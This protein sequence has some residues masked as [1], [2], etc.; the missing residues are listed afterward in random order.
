VD[1]RVALLTVPSLAILG[2]LVTH[3]FVT[4][5]RSRAVAFWSSVVGYGILRGLALRWVIDHGLGASFPY[6]IRNPLF[7]VFGVPAQEIMGWAIVT[8]IGWWL[9]ARFSRYLFAQIAWACLFLGTISWAVESAAVAI[10][11]WRW[12]VP[13]TQSVFV[14]VP[15]I[16]IVDWLFVGIDFLLPFA[17]LTAPELRGRF[18][19]VTL[20]AFPIHFGAHAFVGNTSEII[21]I[22]AYHM[23]HWVLIAALLW[24]AMRSRPSICPFA[25]YVLGCRFWVSPASSST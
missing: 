18:R 7:P 22:P 10:G 8:Y 24:L 11:W 6:T 13:V 14:N 4:L 23:V 3:S 17:T 9:G 15:F 5:P 20:L 12:S 1:N 21:P 2:L 25:R 19:F 16:G